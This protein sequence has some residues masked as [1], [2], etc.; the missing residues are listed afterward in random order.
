M[1]NLVIKSCFLFL[2]FGG[3]FSQA[4][5]QRTSKKKQQAIANGTE[6]GSVNNTKAPVNYNKAI[7]IT[8][9]TTGTDNGEG[10]GKGLRPDRAFGFL[11]DS[12]SRQR[13]P[14]AYEYLRWDDALYSEKVW[15]EL[16]LHEKMNQVFRYGAQDDNGSQMFID[17]L[18]KAVKDGKVTSFEDD[19][20]TKPKALKDI[21]GSIQG[22][23]DTASVYKL[24]GSG[25]VDHYVVT[26]KSFD[27][28]DIM[29]IRVM[30][31][32]VFDRE[33]SRLFCRILGIAP[34][35]TKRDERTG[36]ER[37]SS[38]MF[39][40]YYPDLRPVLATY[41]VYN[42]KNMG[43]SRMTW[44]ELWEARMFSSYITKSTLDNPGNRNIRT[45]IKDPILALLEGD[46]IKE[47]IF[48]YE[49]DLWSY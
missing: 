28:K 20:F 29:K 34:L 9:D 38:V 19:R 14:L 26:K 36:Q 31:E 5:A 10:T 7:P 48:N 11:T 41:D 30:E 45:M 49:Q 23:S 27:P 22:S 1:K 16:D 3:L 32:W 18:M 42:A 39:W 8:F 2:L 33:A 4:N 13:I 25:E 24:D 43:A 47:R 35:I 6:S 40:L 21:L 44:E 15:R 37:G 17:I 12:I 46:N